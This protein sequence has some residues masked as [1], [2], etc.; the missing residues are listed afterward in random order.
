MLLNAKLILEDGLTLN[1]SSFGCQESTSGEVVFNT[2]M[3]GYPECFTD[4]SYE[5]Q[6]LVLTFPLI[7]NYGVPC[8]TGTDL[9]QSRFES[10]SIHI[11][12]LVVSEYSRNYS[13]WDADSSLDD[14]LKANRIPALT[15]LDTRMLTQKLRSHGSMLGKIVI[16]EEP[17]DFYNPNRE[18]L[19][20]K[21]STRKPL[22]YGSGNK[23]V[24]VI[25]CGCKTNIIRS[26][27]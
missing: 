6:I 18:N 19:V 24:I 11:S 20:V 15:G 9:L 27:S 25:D 13:H 21:V 26:F 5:G 4:P 8:D 12:G 14:W 7:G 16:D 10:G 3:V 23:R 17:K 1:C 2:G 22:N